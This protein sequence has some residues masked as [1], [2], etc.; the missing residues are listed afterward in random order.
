MSSGNL[1]RPSSDHDRAALKLAVKRLLKCAGGQAHAAEATRVSTAQ[2]NGYANPHMPDCHMPI[3]ILAD[4]TIDADC[5]VVLE[6]L[7]RIGNGA[8]VPLPRAGARGRWGHEV[9]EAVREGAEAAAALCAA[10]AD[11]GDVT[12]GEIRERRIIEELSEAIEALCV[13]RQHCNDVLAGGAGAGA[14]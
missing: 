8:F 10:M 6:A 4:L 5:A 2:L 9:G 3:D 11:D 1:I 7:C 14:A 13:L 12:A